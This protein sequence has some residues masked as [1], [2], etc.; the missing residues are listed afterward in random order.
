MCSAR[1]LNLSGAGRGRSDGTRVE[2]SAATRAVNLTVLLTEIGPGNVW[3][4][5]H[6][7]FRDVVSQIVGLDVASGVWL[8][9]VCVRGTSWFPR[10]RLERSHPNRRCYPKGAG[11]GELRPHG[12]RPGYRMVAL[13]VEGWSIQAHLSSMPATAGVRTRKCVDARN[14]GGWRNSSFQGTAEARQPHRWRVGNL[15]TRRVNWHG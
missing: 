3:F 1:A 10:T 11:P 7:V 4:E 8:G 9:R 14:L 2:S 15:F 13:L 12:L 6:A 5:R